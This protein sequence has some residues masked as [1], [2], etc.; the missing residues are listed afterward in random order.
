MSKFK[1]YKITKH[2]DGTVTLQVKAVFKRFRDAKT[3]QSFA[4]QLYEQVRD[5]ETGMFRLQ[6]TEDGRLSIKF[7]KGG[8]VI[9]AR[10]YND[11]RLFASMIMEDANLIQSKQ[12]GHR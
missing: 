1:P 2:E 11:A 7:N 9:S 6:D 10:N 8:E 3:L 4:M 5:R 12:D